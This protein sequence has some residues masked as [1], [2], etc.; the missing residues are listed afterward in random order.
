[1]KCGKI[2]RGLSDTSAGKV[3]AS[4]CCS[5][6]FARNLTDCFDGFLG[7]T[8]VHDVV[9]ALADSVNSM[10]G[11]LGNRA[12]QAQIAQIAAYAYLY[13]GLLEAQFA[14]AAT[15][16]QQLAAGLGLGMSLGGRELPGLGHR[17]T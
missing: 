7:G 1:M 10:N 15:N 3:A 4:A 5:T 9:G 14:T 13:E 17:N 12:V 6:R 16:D 2:L 8:L 11:V